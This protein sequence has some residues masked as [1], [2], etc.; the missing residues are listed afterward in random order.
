MSLSML[1]VLSLLLSLLS[2]SLLVRNFFPCYE[3]FTQALEALVGLHQLCSALLP[4][5]LFYLS[6]F[7]RVFLLPYLSFFY[8]FWICCCCTVSATDL[9]ERFL[10]SVFLPYIPFLIWGIYQF[11]LVLS[12]F[13]W[14]LAVLH[15]RLQGLQL[16]LQTQTQAFCFFESHCLYQNV[17]RYR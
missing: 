8:R 13:S 7:Y 9:K 1:S 10:P 3:H 5:L 15:W 11:N 14:K 12:M 16:Q 6:F 2:L 17:L 4:R